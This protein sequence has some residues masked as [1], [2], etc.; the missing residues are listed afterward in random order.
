VRQTDDIAPL[1]DLA[2]ETFAR[3]YN[4]AVDA[5]NALRSFWTRLYGPNEALTAADEALGDVWDDWHGEG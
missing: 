5:V 4:D 1:A 2:D 3:L